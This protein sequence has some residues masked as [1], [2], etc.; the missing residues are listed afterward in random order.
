[1]NLLCPLLLPMWQCFL[2]LLSLVNLARTTPVSTVSSFSSQMEAVSPGM[3]VIKVVHHQDLNKRILVTLIVASTLLCGVLLFLLYF[4]I[5][6]HKIMKNSNGEAKRNLEPTKTISLSPIADQFNSLPMACKKGS[7]AVIEY[8]LLEAATN[9]FRESNVL[10]EGGRGRVYKACFDGKFLAV[11]KKLDG[12]GHNVEREFENEVDW[13]IKIQ[14][15]NIVSLLGYC[16]HGE[17]KLLVYEMMQNGSLES[18]LHGLTRG[19]ALTWQLR[20]KI[21]IDVARALEY[22]HEH[23]NPPVI[24][25]D[26][27]SSNILLD[28]DFNAKLSDFGLAVVTGSQNKNVKLSGTLGYVAPEYLL[29]GKLTDKSDVY[30][31]GIVLL[32][33]LVRKKPLEQMSPSRCQ[34]LVTWAMP[35]L[36]NRSEL[37]NIVDPVIRD[38]MDLKNLYQVA[39]VAVLCIQPEPSY[40]PLITDVLHSLIPLVPMELRGSLRVT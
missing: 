30:A 1:M 36:T 23:C 16:I 34:S 14:H 26:I 38:T 2:S 25:R 28:S 19:S 32:E 15:Q 40:R 37:P 7:V 4:W 12:G 18:Q 3:A 39:A 31:F 21:A 11:V 35:Q 22:L 33:L 20:M 10:G 29:E 17:S 27:K 13:L 5:C 24:H 9:N 8:R 6:R